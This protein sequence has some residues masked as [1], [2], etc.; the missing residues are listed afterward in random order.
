MSLGLGLD[1]GADIDEDCAVG[2]SDIAMLAA[3]WV[4]KY[5]AAGPFETPI[6]N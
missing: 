3:K 4:S 5:A 1:I 6:N 2:M